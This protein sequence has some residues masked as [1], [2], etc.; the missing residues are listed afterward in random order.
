[1][2][3]FDSCLFSGMSDG[4]GSLTGTYRDL[5]GLTGVGFGLCLF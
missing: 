5:L 2:D 4:C 3:W 1:V